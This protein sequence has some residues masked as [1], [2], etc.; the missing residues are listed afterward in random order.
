MNK[1]PAT[2][3]PQRVGLHVR[4]HQMSD[5]SN[6]YTY[7]HTHIRKSQKLKEKAKTLNLV[8]KLVYCSFNSNSDGGARPI[9]SEL[10]N[11]PATGAEMRTAHTQ[12]SW[13]PQNSGTDSQDQGGDWSQPPLGLDSA[14]RAR[15][16]STDSAKEQSDVS[17]GRGCN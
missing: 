13:H 17:P 6:V 3:I 11:L 12:W 1:Y 15:S 16:S 9:R 5:V 7:K 10:Q 14:H 8:F 2:P 4:R